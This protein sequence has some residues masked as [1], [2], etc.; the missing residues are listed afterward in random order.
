MER[1]GALP[2]YSDRDLSKVTLPRNLDVIWCGSLVTHLP[3]AQCVQL[4][5]MLIDALAPGGIVGITWCSRGMDYAQRHI[6]KTINDD[7]YGEI[8]RQ[9]EAAGFGYAPYP[10]WPD[11][12]YGMTFVTMRWLGELIARRTDSYVLSFAEKD[13]HGAQDVLWLVKRPLSH[14]YHWHLD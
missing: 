9:V 4:V 10:G 3:L 11:G 1:F 7:A 13:W 8:A 12:A 6:F 2:V 14:W 5:D